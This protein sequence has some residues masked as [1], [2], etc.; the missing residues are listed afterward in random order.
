M[1]NKNISN[2]ENI[3]VK[4]DQNNLI[5]IDPNT[6]VYDGEIQPRSN[7]AEEMVMYVNLEADLIPRTLLTAS[8]DGNTLKSIAKGNLN[9]LQNKNSDYLDTTWTDLY[10]TKVNNPKDENGEFINQDLTVDTSGQSLGLKSV[11]VVTKGVNFIPYVDIVFTDIRGKTMFESPEESPYAA[12]FHLPW[13]IFYL[14]IKGYYGKAIRYRLHL[15]DFS[16]RYNETNGNFE[17]TTKFIGSTYAYLNDIPLTAILNAPYMYMIESTSESKTNTKTGLKEQNVSSS[18]KGYS[19]LTS[20]YNEYKNKG[21]ISQDFPVKTLKEVIQAAKTLDVTL[22]NEIFS[23]LVDMKLFAGIKDFEDRITKFEAMVN[24]W[25]SKYLTSEFITDT[26]GVVY[27]KL[28][29]TERDSNERIIGKKNNNTLENIIETNLKNLRDSRLFT[30]DLINKTS[31]NFKNV[32]LN[33]I[34]PI[35]NINDYYTVVDNSYHVTINTLL[36]QIYDIQKSFVEQRNNLEDLVEKKMNEVIKDKSKGIGFEPTVRNIFAVLLAGADTYIRLMK[37][38]H[39]QAFDVA[40]ARKKLISNFTN[41]TSGDAIYPW[42]EIMKQNSFNKQ[43]ILAYPRDS[44][45]ISKLNS[46]DAAVWPEVNFV[47]NYYRVAINALD[48]QLNKEGTNIT[49]VFETDNDE[50]EIKP[51]SSFSDLTFVRPYINKTISSILYEIFER[52]KMLT[53][54]DNFNVETIIELA[55]LEF[56]NLQ[57]SI[58]EDFDIVNILKSQIKSTENLKTYMKGFS[59]FERYPYFEDELYTVDYLKNI[60]EKNFITE[61]YEAVQKVDNSTKYPKLNNNL[62]TYNAESYKKNIYPFN[63]DEYISYLDEDEFTLNNFKYEGILKVDTVNGYI[64]SPIEPSAWIKDGYTNNIFAE[65]IFYNSGSNSSLLNSPLFHK[66]LRE[67]FDKTSAYGKFVGSAYLMLNSLAFK[68]L[69]DKISFEIVQDGVNNN[70]IVSNK[71]ILMSS[72][73]REIGSVHCVPYHLI[74]KWGSIYHRYKKY[75]I[76]DIDIIGSSLLPINGQDYFDPNGGTYNGITYSDEVNVGIHPYYEALFHQIV[77]G[78]LHYDVTSGSTEYEERIT[79][80]VLIK[81]SFIPGNGIKYNTSLVDNSYWG[82]NKYTVLPSSAFESRYN[83]EDFDI[84]DQFNYKILWNL[85]DENEFDYS[86]N[87]QPLP[88]NYLTNYNGDASICTNNKKIVDLIATFSP[89]MLDTFEAYFLQFASETLNVEM[90]F[91]IFDNMNNDTFQGLLQKLV[92]VE[93]EST[94]STIPEVLFEDIK[95]KLGIKQETLT[96][97]L[98]NSNSMIKISMTNSSNLD[99]YVLNG[100]LMDTINNGDFSTSQILTEDYSALYLGEDIDGYYYEF[101]KTH[102]IPFTEENI[103]QYRSIIYI[104]AGYLKNGFTNTAKSFREYLDSNTSTKKINLELFLDMLISKFSTLESKQNE[105]KMVAF[106]NGFNEDETVKLELYNT[107]K[108]FN[109]RWI[110]GNSI[111]QRLLMEEFLFLDKANKDIGDELFLDLKKLIPLGNYKNANQ[112]LYGAIT[113]ILQKTNIDLRPL[114]AYVNFYRN[115]TKNNLRPKSSNNIA[116]DLF[117]RFLEVD[118]QDSTPKMIVQYVGQSSK[119]LNLQG[120]SEKY[121]FLNDG[122]NIEDANNNPLLITDED[123]F[124]NL[125]LDKSNKVVSFEVSFGDQNQSIFKSIKLDQKQ[126]RETLESQIAVENLARSENGSGTYQV[127]VSLFDIYRSRSYTC[128]VTCLGDVMIQPTMYFYL[129]NVPMFEG[130]YWIIETLH[131]IQDNLIETKFKGV[132]IPKNSLPNPKESFIATYR[133][134]FDK[135]VHSASA[136]VEETVISDENTTTEET[137][138]TS[139][140][141]YIIDRGGIEPDGEIV[142]KEAGINEFGLQYNGYGGEKYIQKVKIDGKEWFRARVITMGSYDYPINDNQ[143]MSIPPLMTNIIMNPNK[144]YWEDIS[145]KGVVSQVTR[146]RNLYYSARFNFSNVSANKL[147]NLRTIFKTSEGNST[148]IIES[149]YQLDISKGERIVT[150]PVNVGPA[151]SEYGLGLS[152]ELMHRLSLKNGDIVY[153]NMENIE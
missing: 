28:V 136:K 17:I 98:I 125:D 3:L 80:G 131:S 123:F 110:A 23:N 121:K 61:K 67:E 31:V 50:S 97:E 76:E 38:T 113:M 139:E 103:L 95:E 24:N 86:T 81:N 45:L 134:L 39:Y 152:S 56:G 127:D 46:N 47:E 36:S 116:N 91:K 51:I 57:R 126:M 65:Q 27:Y 71:E 135:L 101:F 42:P 140:G 49:Y 147:Q 53:F 108:L 1:V 107:F 90:P 100:F 12:F 44:D 64:S 37:D 106:S 118:Y 119:H 111:G 148:P 117:G 55:E 26:N 77:N 141:T 145:N 109:D 153:F 66:T 10:T 5:H 150:G 112:S 16:S 151:N 7:N 48:T 82:E 132:R 14:T 122:F 52:A 138:T 137:I 89:E 128:E 93:K 70:K 83:H 114:P 72:L 115:E 25:K 78:Y 129:K 146:T 130:T 40:E 104:F 59:P 9:F 43:R 41:E 34:N 84:S 124:E 4:T 92:T 29:K 18:S 88:D 35:S 6:V 94:D 99:P 63:S 133:T 144:L 75:I 149:N 11:N 68:D 96:S 20:V 102:N 62:I 19:L 74:L 58:I 120:I 142:I 87:T 79:N 60:N 2:S 105:S 30:N 22:E 85:V 54:N 69:S 13:P 21:L 15:T 8:D 73:F 33:V 32:D 143:E